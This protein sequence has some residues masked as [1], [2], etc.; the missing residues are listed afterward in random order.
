MLPDGKAAW[1]T[2]LHIPQSTETSGGSLTVGA[3]EVCKPHGFRD[4]V[5]TL[6][7]AIEVE[8][9][10]DKWRNAIEGGAQCM[11]RNTES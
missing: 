1:L 4:L 5:V 7:F 10:T 3:K 8:P 6:G 11:Y 9:L 2:R